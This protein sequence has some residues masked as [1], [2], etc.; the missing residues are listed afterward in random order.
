MTS[1]ECW[2][3]LMP[4]PLLTLVVV[5]VTPLLLALMVVMVM[6]LLPLSGY[7]VTSPHQEAMARMA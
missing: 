1:S 6:L 5:M 3:V 4:T 7:W 2:V